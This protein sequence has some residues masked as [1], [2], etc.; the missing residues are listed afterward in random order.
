MLLICV[1]YADGVTS[2]LASLTGMLTLMVAT[3]IPFVHACATA[4]DCIPYIDA[5]YGNSYISLVHVCATAADCSAR[6]RLGGASGG[7]GQGSSA[8]GKANALRLRGACALQEGV[9]AVIGFATS[10]MY[11]I[12]IV[13]SSTFEVFSCYSSSS[14][15]YKYQD[16]QWA[17][18]AQLL[19]A[20]KSML[21][22]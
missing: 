13:S 2:Q 17:S 14:T 7:T 3:C 12:N 11:P 9:T 21:L 8:S 1:T 6:G 15:R 4:T 22:P 19:L 10:L 5:D 20:S 18:T 16:P